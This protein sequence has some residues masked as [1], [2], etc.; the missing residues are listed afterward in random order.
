ME[1]VAFADDGV[2]QVAVAWRRKRE[3]Q[4][5]CVRAEELQQ[6]LKDSQ[7]SIFTIKLVLDNVVESLEKEEHE[8]VVLRRREQEPAGGESLQ[9]VEQFIGRHHGQTLQVRGHCR[10]RSVEKEMITAVF[11]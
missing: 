10:R 2:H 6:K 5:L 3:A 11:S 8:V 1:H 4:V 7:G 9:Q